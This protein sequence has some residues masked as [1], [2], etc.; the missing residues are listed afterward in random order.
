MPRTTKRKILIDNSEIKVFAIADLHLSGGQDKPMDIFGDHWDNHW[1]KIKE[2]WLI[3]ITDNDV[4][5]IPGDISWAMSLS[6][7][8]VDIEEI[9][10]LPGRQI[11][12]K[13]NH[14]YWWSSLTKVEQILQSNQLVI[15]NNS[16]KIGNYVIAG[17]RGWLCPNSNDFKENDEKIY[18]REA[19]RLEL[20]LEDAKKKM[21]DD[22]TLIVMMHY[23][24][25]AQDKEPT[26][27]TE[28]LE[29][30]APMCVVFGH[31][32]S[33]KMAEK[34]ECEINGI[35]YIMSACDYINFKPKKI[36]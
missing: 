31:I 7:A 30:Y 19:I 12:I 11:F 28:I 14:D 29:K 20:S 17:T 3:N 13:G 36:V 27:F 35:K 21:D 25:F 9:A 1:E 26:V 10:T 33:L 5:L 6:D 34:Y 4:V 18:R 16:H 32:H 23:P 15:Q 22:S 2:N 24:P 8:Q